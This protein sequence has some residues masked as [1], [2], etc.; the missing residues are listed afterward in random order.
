[1]QNHLER[2]VESNFPSRNELIFLL[3]HVLIDQ[4]SRFAPTRVGPQHFGAA[5][6]TAVAAGRTHSAAL[7]ED[8]TL[9]TW[10]QA[11]AGET[12]VEDSDD[13]ALAAAPV[14]PGGLGHADLFD[15]LVPAAVPPHLFDGARVGR[16]H[17]L[18]EEHALAFAMGLHARLGGGSRVAGLAGELVRQV[19]EAGGSWPAGADGT[20]GE[21][22]TR[23]MGG[24]HR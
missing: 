3:K 6:V 14:V 22:V 1:M 2:Y 23:L 11:E 19:V 13:E 16:C 12:D 10:G 5:C 17:R 24:A 4:L 15:R 9:Y 21:G 7:A 8:G 18:P 20:L